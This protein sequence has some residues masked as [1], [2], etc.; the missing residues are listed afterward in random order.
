MD[1]RALRNWDSSVAVPKS[2]CGKPRE[3]V[4]Y[5]TFSENGYRYVTIMLLAAAMAVMLDSRVGSVLVRWTRVFPHAVSE[6]TRGE[7]F[8]ETTK[9][10][11]GRRTRALSGVIRP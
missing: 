3:P 9:R 10:L 5:E 11:C 7:Q 4:R 6:E 8:H 1:H 2:A